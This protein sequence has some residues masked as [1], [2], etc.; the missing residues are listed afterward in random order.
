MNIHSF[1]S[2]QYWSGRA[3]DAYWRWQGAG[4]SEPASLTWPL[5]R[6][7][8][9]EAAI[10]WPAV[11]EWAPFRHW[12]EQLRSALSRFVPTTIGDV[13]QPYKG[14]IVFTLTHRGRRFR[15]NVEVSDYLDLNEAAYDHGDLHFKMQYRL[16]GYGE[17]DRLVPGGYLNNHPDMYAFLPRLRALRDEAPPLYD[18]HGRFGLSFQVR[19]AALGILGASSAFRF[20]GGQTTVRYGSF[21]REITRANICIDLPG[22]GPLTFRLIDYLAIGSCVIGPPHLARLHVPLEDRVHIAYCQPDYS[23]LEELC[24]Y[25]LTHD[26]ERRQLVEASRRFFDTYLHRD[27]L[28]AYYLSQCVRLFS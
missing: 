19:R 16:E 10:I 17:R 1:V 8:L 26:V 9:R 7:L 4:A 27:Q 2:P 22:Y 20:Q 12:G 11:Y 6:E 21:L 18:V 3:V 14:V 13:P 25:Y 5:D 23:D 24:I 15:I 28:A